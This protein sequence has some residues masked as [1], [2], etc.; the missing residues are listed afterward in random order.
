MPRSTSAAALVSRP[1]TSSTGVVNSTESARLAASSGG[2]SGTLYSSVKSST[3]VSQFASF[4]MA[5]FQNT[6]AAPT[7]SGNASSAYGTRSSN[8]IALPITASSGQ[9]RDPEA[10]MSVMALSPMIG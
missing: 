8:P 3:V 10:A 9:R 7:R 1:S 6:A 2:S 4:V 5:E